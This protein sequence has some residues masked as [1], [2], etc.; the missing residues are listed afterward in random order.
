[1]ALSARLLGADEQV[2]MHL[3]TH[4]KV[5]VLPALGLIGAGALTGVGTALIPSD[6]RP[7]GQLAVALVGL[8]VAVWW[9]VIPFLRWWTSTYTVTTR[10]LITREGILNKSG[11]DLPL[12][13]ITG[14]SYSRSLTD[15]ALGCGTLVVRTPVEQGALVLPDVPDVEQVHV[16]MLELLFGATVPPG[17]TVA[18]PPYAPPQPSP[19]WPRR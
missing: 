7:L 19:G 18:P 4:G 1:V 8:A 11:K 13:R 10:R 3:R 5:L 15:R 16:T 9:A 6:Y 2:V 12:V 14:V 17:A